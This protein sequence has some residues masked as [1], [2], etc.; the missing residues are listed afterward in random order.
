M[1]KNHSEDILYKDLE[2]DI[3]FLDRA[4]AF[5]AYFIGAKEKTGETAR[6]LATTFAFG[7]AGA[8]LTSCLQG[9]YREILAGAKNLT[10]AERELS[11]R[12]DALSRGEEG[13][14]IAVDTVTA[15]KGFP[16]V[17]VIKRDRITAVDFKGGL[18][19]AI[20]T[21]FGEVIFSIPAKGLIERAFLKKTETPVRNPGNVWREVEDKVIAYVAR[22]EET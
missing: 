7:V 20:R 6:T 2:G 13:E 10:P 16:Y 11:S 22:K 15:I 3:L 19:V 8:L 5:L 18:D 4:V 9:K 21:T 17:M 14:R 12:L 1:A